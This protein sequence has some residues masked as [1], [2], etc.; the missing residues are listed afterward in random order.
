MLIIIGDDITGYTLQ[1][2][3]NGDYAKGNELD[4]VSATVTRQTRTL[5]DVLGEVVDNYF[6]Y[7][8]LHSCDDYRDLFISALSELMV[9][10]GPHSDSVIDRYSTGM[11][12]DMISDTLHLKR[13]FYLKFKATVPANG[14]INITAKMNKEPYFDYASSGSDSEGVQGYDIVT[15][16][17]SNLHF[18]TLTA[19]LASADKIDIVRQNYGFNLS[20]RITKVKIDPDDEH[21]YLEIKDKKKE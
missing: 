7:T 6:N 15:K 16:L 2:Y 17:G 3:K 10:Y 21:K 9:K 11:I 13:V 19:E 12:D 5:S 14:S 4:G 18:D 8:N 1:G 20:K